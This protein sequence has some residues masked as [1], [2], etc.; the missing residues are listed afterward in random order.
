MAQTA[1]VTLEEAAALEGISYEAIKKRTQRSSDKMEI[2]KEKRESAGKDLT[3]VS[4]NSLS[5]QARNAWRERERLRALAAEPEDAEGQEPVKQERPW[6]V[7]ADVDWFT[8]QYK[9]AYYKGVELGNVVREFLA[10]DEAERTKYAER[11]AQVRL[12]KGARTLYR[13]TKSYLEALAWQE[14]LEK[15]TGCG[16]E[17]FRILCLCRKPKDCGAFPSIPQDMKQAIKN[18]WFNEDFA[19]NRRTRQD[20]YE[21]LEEIGVNKG[22]K[23]LPSYQTVVRYIA[24]LMEDGKLRSA[25]D[26]Q[27]KGIRK[28]KNENMVKRARDTKSLKV[29]EMLQGDEHTFDLWVVYKAKNGREFPIRPKLVCWI[30]TRSRMILGDIICKDADSQILKESL[31]KLMYVD[32]PG[33]VPRYLYIDNGK[34]YT[35]KQ[36]IGVDRKNRHNQAAKD[37]FFDMEFD[38]ATRGFYHDMG[39]EDEHISMPYE[40]WT[41]GQ[42]ERS[43]GTAIEKFSKKFESY[44]GTLTGSST[45]AKIPKEIKK[46]AEQGR[47][48]TM[49]EFYEEWKKYK[50]KYINRAHRGL[51]NAGEEYRTPR[52]VFEKAEQ[53]RKAA[54]PRSYAIMALMKSE[55]A[56]VNNVGIKRAGHYYMDDELCPYI[57]QKIAIKVDPYDVTSIYCISSKGEVICRADSQE[58]LQFGK[59][60]DETLQEHRKMQKRQLRA[61][62]E[63]VAEANIPFDGDETAPHKGMVGGVKLTIGKDAQKKGKVV[64]MP[65]DTTYRQNVEFRKPKDSTYMN[66]QAEKALERLKTM[67]GA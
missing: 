11:F 3:L 37:E 38:R 39:I 55:E 14:K 29:L 6:Y 61:V 30:D 15:E 65:Q 47:L 56:L 13:Y 22:W 5:K 8:H 28:W 50:E 4:V 42:I 32:L 45:S 52:E 64:A 34:D 60:S 20:L 18:I 43:F 12:G 59:I 40:P 66:A 31:V 33:Q 24:Y 2:K 44:T 51:R 49:E 35:S 9:D 48:L 62:R 67:E 41:K 53:Y 36:L 57:G 10:Y 1:Y 58:L 27:Q 7:D 63:A 16:Y 46:L 25:Y 54:P 19:V 17:Y 26:Y 23:K 21:V